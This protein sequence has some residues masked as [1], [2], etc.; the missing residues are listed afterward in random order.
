MFVGEDARIYVVA[1][2]KR[3]SR[4]GVRLGNRFF[5]ACFTSY[6]AKSLGTSQVFGIHLPELGVVGPRGFL[7]RHS[8]RRAT[9]SVEG[10]KLD[11]VELRERLKSTV[12]TVV[13]RGWGMRLQYQSAP[14]TFWQ[15]RASDALGLAARPDLD[16]KIVIH[17][18]AGDALDSSH[19]DYFP[20]PF[21]FYE[22]VIQESQ[23]SP[24]FVGQV[25]SGTWYADELQQRFR[26]AEF[27]AGSAI[28]DFKT[29]ACAPVKVLSIS[30]FAWV[31][32]WVGRTDSRVLIPSAGLFSPEIRPDVDLL[33]SED[34]GFA[35]ARFPV[36][37]RRNVSSTR[38]LLEAL[39]PSSL[40]PNWYDPSH[41]FSPLRQQYDP[42]HNTS[43]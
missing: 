24:L 31:A 30:S 42:F 14:R 3:Q 35:V 41:S 38:E 27:E 23:L 6:V 37:S 43:D 28:E 16:T 2:E 36:I 4:P 20:L 15:K 12:S 7:F 29:L 40:P 19:P 9:L 11:E 26:G 22:R 10:H 5:N 13:V 39:K 18:R 25:A 8:K 21:E 33:P 17:I 32:S 1:G 34:E